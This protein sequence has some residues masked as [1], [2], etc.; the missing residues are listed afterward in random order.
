MSY[1]E[2]ITSAYEQVRAGSSERALVLLALQYENWQNLP[3][4]W[5]EKIEGEFCIKLSHLLLL[6]VCLFLILT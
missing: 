6:L 5:Q 4:D 2:N 1:L 3:R